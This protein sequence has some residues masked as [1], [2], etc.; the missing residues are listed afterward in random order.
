MNVLMC[1]FILLSR[2]SLHFRAVKMIRFLNLRGI[3]GSKMDLVG[4]LGIKSKIFLVP[5]SIGVIIKKRITKLFHQMIIMS[6]STHSIILS[7]YFD[8]F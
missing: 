4:T 1:V 3:F 6:F 8:Y 5:T 7:K 2:L